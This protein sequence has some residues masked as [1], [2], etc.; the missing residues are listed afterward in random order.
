MTAYM[1]FTY[2]TE[3]Y[4]GS[5][6]SLSDFPALAERASRQ[7][8]LITF[9][10]TDPIITANLDL[11]TIEKIKMATCAV[12]DKQAEIRSSGGLVTSERVGNVSVTYASAP[13]ERAL[14]VGAVL[15]YLA[16][17]GLLYAGVE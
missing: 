16:D 17:T 2:Y 10:R 15:P 8:N 9:G 12:V 11:A 1:D 7:V 3:T 6:V 4:L 13:S 14:L 5:V